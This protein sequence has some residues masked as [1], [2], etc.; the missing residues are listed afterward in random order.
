MLRNLDQE[1][2]FWFGCEPGNGG[3]S[4]MMDG[5][6]LSAKRLRDLLFGAKEKRG[7][8]TVAGGNFAS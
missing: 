2:D 5:N 4:D 1:I 6:K 3:T 8:S 7:P